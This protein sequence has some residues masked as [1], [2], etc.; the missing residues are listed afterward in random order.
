MRRS[1]CARDKFRIWYS[2]FKAA[3]RQHDLSAN[4]RQTGRLDLVYFAPR[5]PLLCCFNLFLISVV[6]P[7]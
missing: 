5:F 4:T 1:F 3:D 2:L 6:V 7:V